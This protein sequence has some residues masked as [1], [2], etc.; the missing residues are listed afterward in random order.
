[1]YIISLLHVARPS[2]FYVLLSIMRPEL[3]LLEYYIKAQIIRKK[4]RIND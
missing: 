4:K 3:D 2:G 1:M